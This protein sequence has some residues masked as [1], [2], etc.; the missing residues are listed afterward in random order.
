MREMNESTERDVVVPAACPFCQSADIG[1]TSKAVTV[2]TYWRCAK[3]GQIWNSGRL[4]E[5]RPRDTFRWN[6]PGRR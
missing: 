3:C 4:R 1:T 5:Q 2:S 6:T